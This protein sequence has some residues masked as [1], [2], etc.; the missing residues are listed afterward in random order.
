MISG[1]SW[2][3]AGDCDTSHSHYTTVLPLWPLARTLQELAS[4]NGFVVDPKVDESQ[5]QDMEL[6]PRD[7]MQKGSQEVC[8]RLSAA[9]DCTNIKRARGVRGTEWGACHEPWA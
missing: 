9:A 5:V 2:V 4:A 3:Q 1:H 6:G 8:V 7:P